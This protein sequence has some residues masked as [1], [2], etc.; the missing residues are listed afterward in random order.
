MFLSNQVWLERWHLI[1][2]QYFKAILKRNSKFNMS[3]TV[4]DLR[5]IINKHYEP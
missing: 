3:Q 1:S 4:V 2:K 5:G